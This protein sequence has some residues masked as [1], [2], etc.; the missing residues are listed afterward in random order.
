MNDALLNDLKAVFRKHMLPDMDQDAIDDLHLQGLEWL[1]ISM[2]VFGT[3]NRSI[4]D[5]INRA[6][7]AFRRMRN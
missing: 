4:K 5:A 3:S 7:E 2:L 6:R 1:V